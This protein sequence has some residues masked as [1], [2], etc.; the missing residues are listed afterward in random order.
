MFQSH[1]VRFD[2]HSIQH[3]CTYLCLRPCFCT[4]RFS[5]TVCVIPEVCSLLVHLDFR[6]LNLGP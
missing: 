6:S 5:N 1:S 3:V 2:I 4:V